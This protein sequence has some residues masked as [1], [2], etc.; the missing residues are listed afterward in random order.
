MI[1][2]QIAVGR[3][4]NFTYV[5]SGGGGEAAVV[6]PSWDLGLVTGALDESGLRAKYIINTHGHFDHVTG[7]GEL[8]EITGARIVQ[9]ES[10]ELE[11]DISVAEGGAVEI[12]GAALRVMHTPGHSP[13]SMCLLGDGLIL[14]GDTLFVGSCGR[15]DLPGG[16]ARE[17]YKSLQR[18]RQLED[19]LV[20]YPGHDYGVT[21]TSTIGAEKASNPVMQPR[22]ED[23]FA[24]MMGQ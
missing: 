17:L 11:R 21:P 2:R 15:V 6:D 1:V 4:Q 19:S 23:L 13:D 7:N 10:S 9:H 18:L 20:L 22:T 24:E 14:S 12:A 16:S 5:V 3:M 8:Q